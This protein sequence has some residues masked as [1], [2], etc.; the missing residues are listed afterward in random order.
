MAFLSIPNVSLKGLSAC[1]PKTIIENKKYAGFAPG[2]VDNI[3]SAVGVERH[4]IS[5]KDVCT[6][7]LCYNSAEQ[8]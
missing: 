4:R 1:V 8:Q 3:I 6:S 2:E 5:D 7:D